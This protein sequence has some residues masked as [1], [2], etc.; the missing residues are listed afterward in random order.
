MA[1]PTSKQSKSVETTTP[2]TV[3]AQE[4]EKGKVHIVGILSGKGGVGKSV[5]SVNLSALFTKMGKTNIL[6]DGDLSNPSVGLHL[7][8]SYNAI[9]LS[10]CLDG[11][12]TVG[13]AIVIQPQTGMR[14]LPASLKYKREGSLKKLKS[15]VS[16][17]AAYELVIIDSPPGLTEDAWQI[18]SV[19]DLVFLITTPD[20]PSVT[21]AAKTAA[22]CKKAGAS[23]GGVIINRITK[24]SY[25]LTT[26]EI[27]SMVEAPVI[28]EIPEDYAVPASIAAR[29]PLVLYKPQSPAAKRLALIAK[30]IVGEKFADY[31]KPPGFFTRIFFKIKRLFGM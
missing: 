19:C 25:E 27:S 8:L 4:K 17:L 31:I 29:M 7:G 23:L 20:V 9:G 10:D 26:N 16:Q 3:K 12:H 21:S 6:V 2:E 15:V 14:I 28:G 30:S 22:L 11:H 5:T 18:M 13:D 1:R 24:A